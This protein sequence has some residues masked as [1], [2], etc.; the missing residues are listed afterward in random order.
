MAGFGKIQD[1]K[2]ESNHDHRPYMK[3]S[4]VVS[5]RTKADWL[6]ERVVDYAQPYFS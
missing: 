6:L 4:N 1:P 3:G 5:S 2:E